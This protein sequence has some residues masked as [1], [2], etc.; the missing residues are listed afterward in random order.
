M[1]ATSLPLSILHMY[2]DKISKFGYLLKDMKFIIW[3]HL[4]WSIINTYNI[5]CMEILKDVKKEKLK[6]SKDHVNILLTACG[7]ALKVGSTP[8]MGVIRHW[9]ESFLTLRFSPSQSF[10]S[11]IGKWV[12]TIITRSFGKSVPAARKNV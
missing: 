2:N 10:I 1:Y 5:K 6:M 12:L 11:H 3:S 7:V 4:H 8:K 9:S